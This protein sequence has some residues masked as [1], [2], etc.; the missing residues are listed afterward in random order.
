VE[1]KIDNTSVKFLLEEYGDLY[2][3]MIHVERK[4]FDH[5]ALFVTLFLGLSSVGVGVYQFAVRG[6]SAM[7]GELFPLLIGLLYLVLF[8]VG[9]F[10]LRM[11]IELRIRKMRFIDNIALIRQK[12]W[13]IDQAL[14][15]YLV[16]IRDISQRP[17]SLRI[18]AHDWYQV[19]FMLFIMTLSFFISLVLIWLWL[20]G[21]LLSKVQPLVSSRIAPMVVLVLGWIVC[22]VIAFYACYVLYSRT[23]EYFRRDEAERRKRY[24]EFDE[25][26][27]KGSWD[28]DLLRYPRPAKRWWWTLGDLADYLVKEH[29]I[30]RLPGDEVKD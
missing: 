24:R 8:L 21:C 29:R 20:S 12:F 14:K 23:M 4:L 25:K 10:Q 26:S 28:Y 15:D 19:L 13:E 30:P 7:T 27:E 1:G 18:G 17:P 2:Q 6:E 5:L 22:A 3:N 11:V 9:N 16:L